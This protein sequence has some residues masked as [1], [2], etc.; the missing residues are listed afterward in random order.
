MP[1]T[2]DGHEQ[3]NDPTP[4]V[5]DE[6]TH[7]TEPT[8]PGTLEILLRRIRDGE[9][10]LGEIAEARA[11]VAHDA[12]LPHDLRAG[13]LL[14]ADDLAEDA[15]GLLAVLGADDRFGDALHEAILDEGGVSWDVSVDA[16]A[17]DDPAWA[18]VGVLLAEAV[19]WEAGIADLSVAID[20]AL[21][22]P[23]VA[24]R[25]AVVALAGAPELADEVLAALGHRAVPLARAVRDEAGAAPDV[26]VAVLG[27]GL[28]PIADAV[29]AEAGTV[30][31]ADRVGVCLG[32]VRVP[33]A[34]AVRWASGAVEVSDV[35]LDALDL[36]LARDRLPVA[37]AVRTEAGT[38]EIADRVAQTLS[39][40]VLA[41][42]LDRQL[43]PTTHRLVAARVVEERR[44]EELT[45]MADVGRDLRSALQA[46]AG[47]VELWSGIAGEIGIRDPEQVDGWDAAP[48]V[49]A[50]REGAGD[51]DIA[52]AVMGEV[53]RYASSVEMPLAEIPFVRGA[54]Q[55]GPVPALPPVANRGTWAWGGLW[56]VAVVMLVL[57]LGRM[58][59]TPSV[60]GIDPVPNW[61]FASADELVVED[62]QYASNVQV[63]QL[64]GDDGAVIIWVDEEA[65]L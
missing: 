43:D 20:R 9:A 48:L 41:G 36:R 23:R 38:V 29:H 1:I 61:T 12:R 3:S 19:R 33:V 42:V 62:L 59:G 32:E 4:R 45:A 37:E 50:I 2:T 58:R 25:E 65:V 17:L 30:D 46:E 6:Q 16:A 5:V 28:E 44:G 63:L 52:A 53:R 14:E 49:A 26:T 39:P 8:M 54:T 24:V 31:V 22:A 10:G 13:L 21:D 55:V 57:G 60:Q 56:L 47:S 7:P 27:Q 64:E 40:E 11:L 51:I 34:A 35:V 18:P 15:V